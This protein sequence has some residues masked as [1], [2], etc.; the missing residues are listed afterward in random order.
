MVNAVSPLTGPRDGSLTFDAVFFD[1][2][3]NSASASVEMMLQCNGIDMCSGQC[4]DWA[5][6]PLHCGG[7]DA[8]CGPNALCSGGEC[9]EPALSPCFYPADMTCAQACADL[10]QICVENG[11]NGGTYAWYMSVDGCIAESFPDYS[12]SPCDQYYSGDTGGSAF[13]VMDEPAVRCC[14]A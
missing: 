1:N 14:C 10:G 9:S 7:C 13:I 5:S 4:V 8:A 12:Q 2:E 6:D 3:G 11:C